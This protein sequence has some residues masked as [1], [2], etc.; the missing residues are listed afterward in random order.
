MVVMIEGTKSSD[1]CD[2][3]IVWRVFDGLVVGEV[4]VVSIA[5]DQDEAINA[6]NCA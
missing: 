2:G 3:G 4:E 1:R 6:S 5:F